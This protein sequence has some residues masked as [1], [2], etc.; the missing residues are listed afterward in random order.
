MG[1]RYGRDVDIADVNLEFSDPKAFN[2][3]GA[4]DLTK[5]GITIDPEDRAIQRD[6]WLRYIGK[7]RSRLAQAFGGSFM[8]ETYSYQSD[9]TA[10]V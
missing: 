1:N 7:S 2:L 6:F 8:P 9:P 3:W 5:E 10:F 4:S